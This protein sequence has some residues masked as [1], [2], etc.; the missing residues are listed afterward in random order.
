MEAEIE[1]GKKMRKEGYLQQ[2][3]T[4]ITLAEMYLKDTSGK[5][6][7]K[8]IF[9]A[10]EKIADY[11]DAYLREDYNVTDCQACWNI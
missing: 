2:A 10:C 9:A 4:Y 7:E 8:D 6:G 1:R 11:M 5:H 3:H